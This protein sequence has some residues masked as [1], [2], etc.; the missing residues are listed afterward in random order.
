[1]RGRPDIGIVAGTDSK[2]QVHIHTVSTGKGSIRSCR[3]KEYS[4]C[5]HR[6]LVRNYSMLCCCGRSVVL[7]V[8]SYVVALYVL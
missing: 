5:V 8:A 6:L 2:K 1:M 4:I 3:T 7:Y